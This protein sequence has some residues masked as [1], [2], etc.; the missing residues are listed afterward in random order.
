MLQSFIPSSATGPDSALVVIRRLVVEFGL[1]QW[2]RYALAFS[3]MGVA[4]ACTAIPVYL[5]GHLVNLANVDHDFPGV[6]ALGLGAASI[7]AIKG[8][9]TYGQTVILSRIANHIIAENQRR[10]FSKLLDESIGFFANRHSSEFATRLMTG[11]AAATQVLNLLITSIGRDLF[12]L[13]G[14]GGVMVLQDPMLSIG[15][16]LVCPP[17]MLVLRKMVKRIR[18]IARTQFTGWTRILETL[19]E[20]LQGIR[21]VKAFTLENVLRARFNANV[22]AVEREANKMARVANRT[23]PMMEILGGFALAGAVIYGGHRVIENA[24]SAGALFSFI[25]AFLLAIEPAKRLARFNIDLSSNLV[26]VHVLFEIIDSAPTEPPEDD[27][28]QLVLAKARVEFSH[29]GFAYR[30]GDPVIRD[31]SFVAE[32]AQVT[33]LVGHSGGGKSTILNLIPRFYEASSGVIA[34]DGQDVAKV[35]RRSLRRQ[36]AYVGQDVFLFHGTIRDN[37]A[38]GKP[39]ASEAEIMAA[40]AAAHAHDFIM[41]FAAGYDTP[42]GE[43]GLQVSGGERQR[44]S[45]ARALVKNAPII[46]L[47]EATAA[48]DSESERHVQDAIAKLCQ[49]RTTIV[50]AHRLATVMH[51]DRILV[52]EFGQIVETG[53]H[54]ELLRKG[55]RYASFCRLQL[56]QQAPLEATAARASLI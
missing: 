29:V 44:I 36:I 7:F 56:E 48:L 23:S 8:A 54:D 1:G 9:A 47:D 20:T 41:G 10:L 24:A 55:G 26:A 12:S 2:R 4:A 6:V 31:L 25:T 32:P 42:V 18:G 45:I 34:I 21:I 49:G 19:Q 46:L 52:I 28:P 13:I 22:A 39:G 30:P 53:R 40:A 50:I 15:A 27:R 37:I 38:F 11:A 5:I 16:L 33:A 35:S 14:L 17:A 43:R 51:A 3:L